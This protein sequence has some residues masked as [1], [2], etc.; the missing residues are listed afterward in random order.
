M[1]Y[2]SLA[3]LAVVAGCSTRQIARRPQPTQSPTAPDT[4]PTSLRW[5]RSSAEHRAI[6]LEVYGNATAQLERSAVGL[7][8]GKWAVVLDADET[9]LDNS[10]YEQERARSGLGYSDESWTAWVKR[11]AATALPGAVAFTARAHS[12]GGRV[13]IVSNRD[14]GVCPETRQNLAKVG[15]VAD[16][17]L[18]AP[19]G[20]TDKNPRFRAIEDGTASSSL[21]PLRVVIWVG[22]NIEDFPRLHQD[23]RFASDSAMSEFGKS[24]FLVPN[25]MYG[26][27]GKNPLP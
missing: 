25:P 20:Q 10:Q 8:A 11:N 2:Y 17:V 16:L 23:I 26:S 18:C 13:V 6:F 22:D 12:L 15:L 14:E 1:R 9:T 5:S 27:W 21:P 24:Y 4:V 7:P 3:L 19:F